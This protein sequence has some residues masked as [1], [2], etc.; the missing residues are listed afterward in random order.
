[1]VLVI[2]IIILLILAGITIATLMG[3]NGLITKAEQAKSVQIK[4]EMEEKLILIM[5]DLQIEN[6]GSATLEDL[7][8]DYFNE[9]VKD[10]KC[11]VEDDDTIDGKKII[12]EKDGVKEIFIIGQDM[13]IK[14]RNTEIKFVYEI[15]ETRGEIAF[16]L[17]SVEDSEYGIEKVELQNKDEIIA[18]GEKEIGIDYEVEMGKEY[19]IK[20]TSTRGDVKTGK[21]LV[22]VEKTFLYNEGEDNT[23]LTGGFDIAGNL[24]YNGTFTIF[25]NYMR[26]SVPGSG[27][28]SY[29]REINLLNLKDYDKI[30]VKI[31]RAHV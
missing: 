26:L 6:E 27:A 5:S 13:S 14:E 19:Q 7:T 18:N 3:Q 21:I 1:M 30:C 25:D 12:M 4:A 2:T 8:Q 17:I 10:Y 31:G 20:I 15:K 22:N 9:N 24:K 28:A 23:E 16:L 11:V 29:I